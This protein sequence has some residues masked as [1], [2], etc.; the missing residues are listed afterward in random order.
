MYRKLYR[1]LYLSA[2]YRLRSM[3]GGRLAGLVRP[4]SIALLLTARCNARCV[5]C[6]IWKNDG[7]EQDALTPAE[8][9]QVLLEM[10]RWLG[11]V[12]ICITGSGV[13]P[14]CSWSS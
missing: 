8:W 10:R 4:T 5:H 1:R 12:P 3:L 6:D 11:P 2:N 7:K 9:R 14:R 13:R